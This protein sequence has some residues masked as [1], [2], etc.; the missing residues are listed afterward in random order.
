[1]S[2]SKRKHSFQAARWLPLL[3][4]LPI[5][6]AF[7]PSATCALTAPFGGGVVHRRYLS[8]R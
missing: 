7:L 1:M 8:G 3:M 2:T 5:E 4:R 6:V